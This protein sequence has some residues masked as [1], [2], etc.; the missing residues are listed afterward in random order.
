M[1]RWAKAPS[2]PPAT[3]ARALPLPPAKT[4]PRTQLAA[5]NKALQ[6]TPTM[7]AVETRSHPPT[8]ATKRGADAFVASRV[9]AVVASAATSA[10]VPGPAAERPADAPTSADAAKVNAILANQDVATVPAVPE[11]VAATRGAP[12]SNSAPP[13][14]SD[15]VAATSAAPYAFAA[16]PAAALPQ[17][18]PVVETP[19]ASPAVPNASANS[20]RSPPVVQASPPSATPIVPSAQ[21]SAA[22]T[23][24]SSPPLAMP[25]V[26]PARPSADQF[27]AQTRPG[28][29]VIAEAP[30]PSTPRMVAEQT[31]SR[32]SPGETHDGNAYR[33]QASWILDNIV[34]RT[35]AQSQAQV[36]RVLLIAASAYRPDQER[37][38]TAAAASPGVVN[39]V[40]FVVRDF[41]PLDA[42]R[43]HEEARRAFW[44]RRDIPEALDLA[45]KAFGANPYDPEISG[46]LAYL[47]MKVLPAQPDRARQ[48]ALH[49]IGMRNRQYQTG[50]TEDWMTFAIASAL[51]G[52]ETDAR[53][54]FYTLVA[55]TRNPDLACHAALGALATYGERLREPVD[56]LLYRLQQQ[57]RSDDSPDCTWPAS[58]A[59]RNP[60]G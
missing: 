26:P 15:K 2:L 3:A 11:K 46:Y 45:L 58:R 32:A 43:W 33:A 9:P 25:I 57:G 6:S 13:P 28:A 22:R 34:P 12:T 52:R 27:A 31:R 16:S 48:L 10:R 23:V 14:V 29:P 51:T 56:A 39:D 55:L 19:R 18:P 42:R 30:R 59:Q 37:V 24:E 36:S 5:G 44:S 17:A 8:V 50:R 38:V 40:A 49:A 54:G 53:Y 4:A 20:S 21:T 47:Y 1:P 60:R 41:A 7:R 35:S